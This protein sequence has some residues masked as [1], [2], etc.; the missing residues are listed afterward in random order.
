MKLEY[1]EREAYTDM[2]YCKKCGAKLEENVLICSSCGAKVEASKSDTSAQTV[3]DQLQ[4]TDIQEE[5]VSFT[6]PME[7]PSSAPSASIPEARPAGK[8]RRGKRVLAAVIAAVLVVVG[9]G[10]IVYASSDSLQNSVKQAF[11]QPEDYIQHVVE[12]SFDKLASDASQ[13]YTTLF[14]PVATL[15]SSEKTDLGYQMTMKLNLNQDFIAPFLDASDLNGLKLETFTADIDASLK[16]EQIGALISLSVNE[17]QLA[18]MNLA[19]NEKEDVLYF[20]IPEFTSSYLKI[21]LQDFELPSSTANTAQIQQLMKE[22]FNESL[23]N[24]KDVE[25]II[26]IYSKLI[27]ELLTDVSV[28]KNVTA[29]AAGVSATYN[30]YTATITEQQLYDFLLK[31]LKEAQNDETIL[32]FLSNSVEVFNRYSNQPA[33]T[34]SGKDIIGTMIANLEKAT[35]QPSNVM[36]SCS[37][38]I[39]DQGEMKGA[40]FTLID[41]PSETYSFGYLSCEKKSNYGFSFWMK[42]NTTEILNLHVNSVKKDGVCK[43]T[44]ELTVSEDDWYTGSLK[45]NSITVDFTLNNTETNSEG[46]FTLSSTLVPG[47]SLTLTFSGKDKE[48][49]ISLGVNYLGMNMATASLTYTETKAKEISF[50]SASDQVYTVTPDEKELYEYLSECDINTLLQKLSSSIGIDLNSLFIQYKQIK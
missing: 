42:E 11:W 26:T 22:L 50:P 15:T 44:A 16:G 49:D 38:W 47:G 19:G 6:M 31:L 30:K 9:A 20:Q 32:N 2:K 33:V 29:D 25:R 34:Y 10:A 40:E 1:V 46:S 43:G 3:D 41:S 13:S 39:N 36:G 7:K 35:I 8:K 23:L 21:D 18:S 48:R 12:R 37:F 4:N 27:V 28:E 45:T 14:A 5:P 17:Q 24:E